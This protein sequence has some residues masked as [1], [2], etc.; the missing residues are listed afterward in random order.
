MRNGWWCG[1][2]HSGA[3]KVKPWPEVVLLACLAVTPASA[4]PVLIS[5]GTGNPLSITSLSVDAQTPGDVL[6]VAWYLP[7]P[8][9]SVSVDL[10][11]MDLFGGGV[12]VAY[13]M[14]GI[15][16]QV[17]QT[18]FS[19]QIASTTFSAGWEPSR[20]QL[21][22]NL[23]LNPGTYYLV[24][25]TAD[26]SSVG[27]WGATTEP[28]VNLAMGVVHGDPSGIQFFASGSDVNLAYLPA[29]NFAIDTDLLA[30]QL[31]YDVSIPEPAQWLLWA[32]GLLVLCRRR[33]WRR[34]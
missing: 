28:V 19:N 15:G 24:V 1:L 2:L 11:F 7:S 12:F 10:D 32:S 27:G 25:G 14:D 20:L 8:Y 33:A 18:F 6:A 13:L 29:S 3:Q 23:V 34:R 31:M 5:V 30:G 17:D 22:T 26:P 9:S 4:T 21:W 16:P